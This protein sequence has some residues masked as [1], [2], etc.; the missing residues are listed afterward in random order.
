MITA[1]IVSVT[2]IVLGA[3]VLAARITSSARAFGEERQC[4]VCTPD[5]KY[6]P[7]G[8]RRPPS[9]ARR[10]CELPLGHVGWHKWEDHSWWT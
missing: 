2:A 7:G 4:A 9:L 6:R 1:A 10:R 8:F 5:E 3:Y